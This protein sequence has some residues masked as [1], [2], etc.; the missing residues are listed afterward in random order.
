M[1]AIGK[2]KYLWI[3]NVLPMSIV[4]ELGLSVAGKK[5][6]LSLIRSFEKS[7]NVDVLSVSA[8]GYSQSCKNGFE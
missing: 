2:D 7:I 6:E 1:G 5:M 8:Q 4:D 3:S